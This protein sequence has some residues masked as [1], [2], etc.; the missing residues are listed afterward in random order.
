MFASLSWADDTREDVDVAA[1]K[2]ERRIV[3]LT[4]S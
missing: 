2:L 3:S 4:S 1:H